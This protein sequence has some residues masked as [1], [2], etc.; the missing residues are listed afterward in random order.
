[1]W[2]LLTKVP[3]PSLGDMSAAASQGCAT[4]RRLST[5]TEFERSARELGGWHVLHRVSVDEITGKHSRAVTH[6]VDF[7]LKTET[8]LLQQYGVTGALVDRVREDAQQFIDVVR[9]WDGN[10]DSLLLLVVKLRDAACSVS[11]QLSEQ[12]AAQQQLERD[13]HAW[14]EAEEQRAAQWRRLILLTVGVLGLAV[15]WLNA[16][17]GPLSQAGAAT[18][19]ALGTAIVSAAASAF[20]V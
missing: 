5:D 7:F 14:K 19:A 12:E 17:P 1:M 16:L 4:L 8:T 18:S 15:V 20:I 11:S 3:E 6:F 10:A 9:N 13:E 2:A